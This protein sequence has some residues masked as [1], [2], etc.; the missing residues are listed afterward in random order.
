MKVLFSGLCALLLALVQCVAGAPVD[1]ASV[2]GEVVKAYA[3]Q[4]EEMAHAL[5]VLQKISADTS[6]A[7]QQIQTACA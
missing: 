5:E 4:A 7:V 6:E 3:Q 2:R 1:Y